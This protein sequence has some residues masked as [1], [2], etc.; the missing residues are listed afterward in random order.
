MTDGL[1]TPT[2]KDF[3]LLRSSRSR[4]LSRLFVQI[5]F[6]L[7][8]LFFLVLLVSYALHI[9]AGDELSAKASRDRLLVL[10]QPWADTLVERWDSYRTWISRHGI[11]TEAVAFDQISAMVVDS[12]LNSNSS[13]IAENELSVFG[14][15]YLQLHA[16]VVRLLF[17]VCASFRLALSAC[18]VAL[19]FGF[20]SYKPYRKDDALGQMGNGRVFYSGVRASLDTL[21][22]EGAPD[23][24]VRGFACPQM[25]SPAEA[26]ASSLCRVL[27]QFGAYNRTNEVLTQ[28]LVK[29]G[30]IA[31]Y[32]SA[33]GDE[34]LLS[35]AFAGEGLA[36]NAA[37]IVQAALALHARYAT[38]D[39]GEDV[40]DGSVQSSTQQLGTAEYAA[41]IQKALHHVLTPAS[42]RV[43]AALPAPEIATLVLAFESGKV[44]AHS[45]EG[46]KWVR[47]S[48]F[49][50]LS[51]R[52]V[53]HSITEYPQDY[54]FYSRTRIR[55]GL[56]YAARKSAF[57][58]VRMPIDMGSEA[59]ALRQW[60]E[61]LLACPH[62]LASVA[63]EVELVGMVREVHQEWCKRFFDQGGEVARR[64][65]RAGF[66]TP[67]NLLFLPVAEIV[68]TMRQFVDR[69]TIERMHLL[70]TWVSAQQT[71]E[72]GRNSDS[73]SGPTL[74]LSFDRIEAM[75]P[76]SE[77]AQL[78]SIHQIDQESLR[79][80]LALRIILSAYGWIASRVGDYSVP[81]TSII[82]AVFRS[83]TPLEGINPLGLLG[84]PGMVPLRGS[85]LTE[86]WG[87]NWSSRFTY[88]D[89]ATMGETLE[90]YGKL[91]QGIEE[92]KEVEDDVLGA[93][94]KVQA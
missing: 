7:A 17:L 61:V 50:H 89:K 24:Q 72:Q 70:L 1:P 43:I 64:F 54:D 18:L 44:L 91:L 3:D 22:A 92:V 45:F 46:G 9:R 29:N 86:R 81:H 58:P 60:A 90:D 33:A 42:R 93:P 88:V 2:D 55:G 51:A 49:P 37:L 56:I 28:I 47:R 80:W 76:D 78:A 38:G 52:A 67:T 20:I 68:A 19:Y 73:E 75:P 79:D 85:K 39:F 16:G 5:I 41:L 23:V 31:A 71:L 94:S 82:F 59:W 74:Q 57:S 10:Q 53:L 26:K 62:E 66:T 32:V 15:F 63:R 77:I 6:G 30:D 40:K 65:S 48:N 87:N 35:K 25:A 34:E 69:A 8:A 36:S 21:T 27:S 12:M 84:R 13:E 4:Q 83:S 11:Q 14:R